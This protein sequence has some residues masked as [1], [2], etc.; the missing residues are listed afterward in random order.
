MNTAQWNSTQ[1]STIRNA[2]PGEPYKGSHS[3]WGYVQDC[4]TI[5]DGIWWC[6]TARHGG[7]KLNRQ[8]NAQVPEH[9]RQ[10]GG[11]YEEDCLWSV[12]Y[13]VFEKELYNSCYD[14][15]TQEMLSNDVHKET[16]RNW[17]PAMYEEFYG[18][19]LK[20]GESM[21]RDEDNF[22]IDHANDWIV[23]S[24]VTSKQHE[25]MVECTACMGGRPTDG[26]GPHE[27]PAEDQTKVFLVPTSEYRRR[28]NTNFIIDIERHKEMPSTPGD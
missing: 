10:H 2:K 19:T 6:F 3:K 4:Q 12:V 8:R 20:P 11:W 27:L 13:C 28:E 14:S 16:L 26:P 7:I 21:K 1:Q 22:Y 15:H 24:A 9:M 5:L 23:F 25:G 18:V 17:Y